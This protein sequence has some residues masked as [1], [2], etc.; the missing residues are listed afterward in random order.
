MVAVLLQTEA[1]H[2]LWVSQPRV[3]AKEQRDT[4][5]VWATEAQAADVCTTHML[6]QA[7]VGR[8]TT[9]VA[10]AM[11]QAMEDREHFLLV[12]VAVQEQS[13]VPHRRSQVE[14]EA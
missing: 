6:E 7:Q 11:T 12:E 3:V 2:L 1:T 9:V 14:L 4:V 8:E 13:A 5:A 10:L